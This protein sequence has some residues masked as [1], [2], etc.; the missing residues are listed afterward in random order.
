MVKTV[1]P[2]TGNLQFV[3]TDSIRQKVFSISCTAAT[4]ELS[5]KKALVQQFNEEPAESEP[6]QVTCAQIGRTFK[7]D[8]RGEKSVGQVTSLPAKNSSSFE[9]SFMDESE[10]QTVTGR[11]CNRV[12]K[13]IV[14]SHIAERAVLHG[15]WKI[16]KTTPVISQVALKDSSDAEKFTFPVQL[17]GSLDSS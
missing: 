10:S 15:I 8:E 1:Q 3:C 4:H 5:T 12:D 6:T 2:T 16:N 11:A 17:D 13:S 9:V 7:M 14:S